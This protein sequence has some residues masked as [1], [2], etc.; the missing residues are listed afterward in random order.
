MLGSI[1]KY[2]GQMATKE[3]RETL[4]VDSAAAARIIHLMFT[5][6]ETT[7]AMTLDLEVLDPFFKL[8]TQPK[9][10]RHGAEPVRTKASVMM[11]SPM[12]LKLMLIE[13]HNLTVTLGY[14]DNP[15]VGQG[16]SWKQMAE[17]HFLPFL[18]AGMGL[19]G[20]ERKSWMKN[21][22]KHLRIIL[23][24]TQDDLSLKL[25]SSADG[26]GLQ[27]VLADSDHQSFKSMQVHV[28]TAD[29]IAIVRAAV[30]TGSPGA[31][32]NPLHGG[33]MDASDEES[34]DDSVT[35]SHRISRKASRGI[36]KRRD[37]DGNKIRTSTQK[38]TDGLKSKVG[39]KSHEVHPSKDGKSFTI[40]GV[41]KPFSVSKL[42]GKFP[43]LCIY[44]AAS[45]AGLKNF[46]GHC[47]FERNTKGH[48]RMGFGCHKFGKDRKE[49]AATCHVGSSK[50][51]AARKKQQ[52]RERDDTAVT[53]LEE[54][55]GEPA[56]AA[57]QEPKAK[58]L[59][60]VPVDKTPAKLLKTL[61]EKRVVE[62]TG[63]AEKKLK[64]KHKGVLKGS[65]AGAKGN[66]ASGNKK[67]AWNKKDFR[68][69]Q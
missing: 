33:D 12:S 60:K 17:Q 30:S 28:T 21:L 40:E 38:A 31:K 16:I 19:E 34:D 24:A 37:T 25:N 59:V 27:G 15:G 2:L 39:I 63:V 14:L 43:G 20:E 26:E 18:E 32:Y 61:I 8:I 57:V 65:R 48:G 35:R 56:E 62:I 5:E 69:G 67:V 52:R 68:Q 13:W 54:H 23:Q 66:K 51:T 3:L 46:V 45:P 1:P 55:V 53:E 10:V 7:Q 49:L 47:K 36:T 44:A 9:A 4:G 58:A 42:K 41:E 29:Q 50:K 6:D 64:G 11:S 22:R